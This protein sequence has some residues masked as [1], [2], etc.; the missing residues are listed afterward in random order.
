MR[1]E[2][3]GVRSRLGCGQSTAHCRMSCCHAT[4]INAPSWMRWISPKWGV[5][6]EWA[7]KMSQR[8][9]LVPH[10]RA[11]TQ[12]PE[13]T[14][15][16]FLTRCNGCNRYGLQREELR[17][18]LPRFCK[19][20]VRSHGSVKSSVPRFCKKRPTVQFVCWSV[21]VCRRPGGRS[22]PEGRA[23]TAPGHRPRSGLTYREAPGTPEAPPPGATVPTTYPR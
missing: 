8:H 12:R 14:P 19:K 4:M 6:Y 21:T 9:T 13:H 23:L 7:T 16:P 3:W 1:R 18:R 22:R 10:I 15:I 20:F 17:M 2:S 5:G 11:S